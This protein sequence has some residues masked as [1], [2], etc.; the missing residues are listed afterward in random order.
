MK[1]G[2]GGG[3]EQQSNMILD[4]GDINIILVSPSV[5]AFQNF[6]WK[7]LEIKTCYLRNDGTARHLDIWP[8]DST[9]IIQIY[10][11]DISEFKT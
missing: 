9:Y 11:K 5:R 8:S 1:E 10:S 4:D 6:Q 7:T 3:G 2:G